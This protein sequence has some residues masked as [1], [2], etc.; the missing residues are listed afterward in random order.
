MC[1]CNLTL[2]IL[3]LSVLDAKDIPNKCSTMFYIKYF[4]QTTI[5]S[6]ELGQLNSSRQMTGFTFYKCQE[7]S[8]SWFFRIFTINFFLLLCALYSLRILTLFENVFLVKAVCIRGLY[9]KKWNMQHLRWQGLPSS[10]FSVPVSIHEAVRLPHPS[11]QLS[12]I[13]T[14]HIENSWQ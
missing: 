11:F 2:A 7:D 1:R 14:W 12:Q 13:G 8:K 4:L 3:F 9:L 10:L 5:E 6:L